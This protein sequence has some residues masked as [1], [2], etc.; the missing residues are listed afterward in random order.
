MDMAS[1]DGVTRR[2]FLRKASA[3][4]MLVGTSLNAASYARVTGAN[5]RFTLGLIGCGGRG[6]DLIKHFVKQ[7]GV[8]SRVC[9]PDEGRMQQART[10]TERSA[11]PAKDFRNVRQV[12]HTPMS[13]V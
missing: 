5:E 2:R 1:H 3:T 7:G 12:C 10:L 8:F 11:E 4:T 13:L 6:Q 9:D